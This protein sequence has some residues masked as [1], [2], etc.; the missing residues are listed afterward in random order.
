MFRFLTK[1]PS[2]SREI[3]EV[4]YVKILKVTSLQR[5]KKT[6]YSL[7][8][9]KRFFAFFLT[10]IFLVD[11]LLKKSAYSRIAPWT[12]ADPI[13]TVYKDRLLTLSQP[14]FQVP[15]KQEHAT[16]LCSTKFATLYST[17]KSKDGSPLIRIALLNRSPLAHSYAD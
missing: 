7:T 2:H 10:T 4:K 16:Q 6:G 15:T 14:I 8:Q 9:K 17:Y 3:Y 5:I 1:S 12:R 11:F 13:A